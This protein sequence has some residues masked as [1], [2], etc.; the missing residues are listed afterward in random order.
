MLSWASLA[1]GA[2]SQRIV[3]LCTLRNPLL[4]CASLRR[5]GSCQ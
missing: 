4:E 2:R 5:T 3:L 1:R